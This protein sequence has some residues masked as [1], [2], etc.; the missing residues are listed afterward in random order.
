MTLGNRD[1]GLEIREEQRTSLDTLT[2]FFFFP[3][4]PSP[5]P[6]ALALAPSAFC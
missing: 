3:L 4:A 5:S 1:W 2:P 6:D